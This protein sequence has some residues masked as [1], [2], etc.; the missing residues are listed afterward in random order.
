MASTGFFTA[1]IVGFLLMILGLI[2]LKPLAWALGS[3]ELILPKAMEY[4]KLILIGAPYM[5]GAL[6]LNNQLRFQGSAFLLWL[7]L[8]AVLCL[9]LFL[10]LY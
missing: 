5:V 3:T 6:V 9:I 1:I 10:T 4:M 7:A 2:F 8:Q